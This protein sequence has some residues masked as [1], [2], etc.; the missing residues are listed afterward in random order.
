MV[1]SQLQRHEQAPPRINFLGWLVAAAMLGMA[2]GAAIAVGPVSHAAVVLSA[3]ALPV[4]ALLLVRRGWTAYALLFLLPFGGVSAG[5]GSGLVRWAVVLVGA[6][7][8]IR[9]LTV[10]GVRR[11]RL[12]G[13]DKLVA[14]WC[15][16]SATSALVFNPADGKALGLTYGSLFVVYYVISRSLVSRRDRELAVVSLA[17]GLAVAGLLSLVLWP[18]G[19]EVGESGVSRAGSVGVVASADSGGNGVNRFGAQLTAGVLL[20]WVALQRGRNRS[21]PMA[22]AA[23]VAAAVALVATA[24]RGAIAALGLGCIVWAFAFPSR[25]RTVRVGAVILG[26]IVALA[27][28]PTTLRERFDRLAEP[29]G[30]T[31]RPAVW[32]G[33]VEMFLEHP[34]TGVGVGNFPERIPAYLPAREVFPILER[35]LDAH[36][37]YIATLAETGLVGAVVFVLVLIEVGRESLVRWKHRRRPMDIPVC[38]YKRTIL[39]G[40]GVSFVTFLAAGATMDLSRDRYLFALMGLLHSAY[41]GLPTTK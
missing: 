16:I 32:H 24:S 5:A 15:V 19:S 26:L 23:S 31:V 14:I 13:L 29:G 1:R 9:Y 35:N 4:P 8:L 25:M 11:F 12:D 3:L 39:A 27:V 41:R 7:W 22:R 2:F 21:V 37:I 36:S 33:G 34:V 40:F 28:A 30:V 10:V 38:T 6:C 20:P 17:L 18:G